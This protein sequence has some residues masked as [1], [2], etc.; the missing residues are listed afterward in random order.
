M[1][2]IVSLILVITMMFALTA[3]GKSKENVSTADGKYKAGTYEGT[4][5]GFGG[6]IKATVTLTADKIE[7]IELVGDKETQGIGSVAVEQL[8]LIHI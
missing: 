7:K 6:E 4:A 3:C 2:R 8:S 5:Q 1:K